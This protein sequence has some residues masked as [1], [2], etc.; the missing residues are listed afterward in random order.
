MPLK[1]TVCTFFICLLVGLQSMGQQWQFSQQYTPPDVRSNNLFGNAVDIDGNYAIASAHRHSPVINGDTLTQSGAAYIFEKE[2]EGNWN[3]AQKLTAPDA[4]AYDY[5]GMDVG[6][7]GT[8][9]VVGAHYNSSDADNENPMPAAGAVYVFEWDEDRGTWQFWQKLTAC[10]RDT[11]DWFGQSLSIHQNRLIVGAPGEDEDAEGN[12]HLQ[13][14]GSAYIFEKAN[15]G[16]WY[17]QQKIVPE[18]REAEAQF[19]LKVK[20]YNDNLVV[21]HFRYA[22]LEGNTLF[23]H[24]LSTFS[25]FEEHWQYTQLFKTKYDYTNT[26]D[27]NDDYLVIYDPSAKRYAVEGIPYLVYG[28]AIIAYQKNTENRWEYKD[29]IFS[30]APRNGFGS[31]LSI[32]KNNEIFTR[33]RGINILENRDT[34]EGDWLQHFI[35]DSIKQSWN[36]D[37]QF[38]IDEIYANK[39]A[40]SEN[41]AII[42][43]ST[44]WGLFRITE[45]LFIN[46]DISTS[47]L[48]FA[49]TA[50]KLSIYPNPFQQQFYIELPNGSNKQNVIIF[51]SLMQSVPFLST[52]KDNRLTIEIN[53]SGQLFFVQHQKPGSLPTIQP[54]TK[55]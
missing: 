30:S 46:Y 5:F 27:I 42:T 31:A 24:G 44:E 50:K 18:Y 51:N 17:E 7:S 22:G 4:V 13:A 54:I 36:I 40:Y 12:N 33:E 34:I 15:D 14:A 32:N 16:Y 10:D 19:G 49:N 9:A 45:V 20:I 39:I 21:R 2:A 52:K 26:A 48:N 25:F 28:S 11:L 53:Q 23:A 38:F 47:I 55:Y 1:Q 8:T 43:L 37:E 3:E 6:I 41:E 29:T 35:L